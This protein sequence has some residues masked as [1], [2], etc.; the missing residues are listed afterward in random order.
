[1]GKIK[2]KGVLGSLGKKSGFGMLGKRPM[3]GF[4]PR[5]IKSGV[6]WISKHH[7]G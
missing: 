7:I 2:L 5:V 4:V 3:V 1:L 6:L